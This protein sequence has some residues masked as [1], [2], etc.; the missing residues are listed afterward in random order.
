MK[1]A[2][3]GMG[4]AGVS[5]LK[6][7]VKSDQFEQM[8][9]DVYDNPKNMGQG[10]PFQNDSD[11]LLI[12]LPAADMSLNLDNHREFYEWYE[13]QTTF[14]FSNTK[15][16]PRF[17]F[18][19]YMKDYLQQYNYK[20]KNICLIQEEVSEV[21][22]ES[23]IGNTDVQYNVCTSKE[24]QNA[25][26]Y[27]VVFLCIGTLT[28]HD[29]YNLKGTTG[30]IH[31]PYPTYNTLDY[32]K[33]SD[34]ISIIGTGLASLD[35]IRYV[36]AHHP[37]LPITVTSR[38][39]HLPSVRGEM[40]ELE[41]KYVTPENF[42]EIKQ[43]NFGN[44]PLDDAICLFLKDCAELEIPIERLVHRRQEDVILDLTYDLEHSEILGKFQ[45]ILELA[46]ENLNWIWNSFS[47]EDQ[48]KFLADYQW[49]L[50]EN[51]NPMPPQTA[52]LIIEHI[53]NG[54]IEIKEGLESVEKV[55]LGF[56]LQFEDGTS[57]SY[58]IVINATGSKTHLADLDSDDQLV[59]NLENRQVVQAHPL[60]GI[61]IVAET[62]QVISPRYGTLKGMYALGQLTNG[63]NQSRNG[64]MMIV[65]QAVSVVKHLL[66]SK[67]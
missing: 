16:L 21:Y 3:I 10:V 36:T 14:K 19:H 20:Y 43:R 65:K 59:L 51:S 41:F 33:D 46:K 64:V 24:T 4:T 63:I 11:Q 5:V 55:D 39:G 40:P 42:N 7:L 56:Q 60:G 17:I 28:Y 37:N 38:K 67:S 18:G 9:V 12:N 34:R 6:E 26:V 52:R 45:S 50:K 54:I 22:I 66:E 25:K 2:I 48:K 31:T 13:N 58:D 32:V 23:K 57:Q 61:Q 29:P 47:R 44:V 30:Y 27:D 1:I 49:I 62:N 8:Q 53:E 35:V 15:Y